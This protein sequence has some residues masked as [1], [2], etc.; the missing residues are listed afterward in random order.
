MSKILKWDSNI[1]SKAL[2]LITANF[3][4]WAYKTTL[5]VFLLFFTWQEQILKLCIRGI[6]KAKNFQIWKLSNTQSDFLIDCPWV[7][8]WTRNSFLPTAVLNSIALK[9]QLSDPEEVHLCC[10]KKHHFEFSTYRYM[11]QL[12]ND[13][14]DERLIHYVFQ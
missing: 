3:A 4:L 2:K 6:L 5:N 10:D 1:V 8:F 11:K 9:S 14:L 7:Q 13:V 12:C